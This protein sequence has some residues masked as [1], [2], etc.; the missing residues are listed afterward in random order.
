VTI[1]QSQYRTMLDG[2]TDAMWAR[3]KDSTGTELLSDIR[4]NQQAGRNLIVGDLAAIRSSLDPGQ[5]VR[6]LTKSGLRK[7]L[8]E[9]FEYVVHEHAEGH[10]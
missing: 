3:Y 10:Q 4:R 8:D 2:R 1:G 6:D 7:I 5:K 9:R